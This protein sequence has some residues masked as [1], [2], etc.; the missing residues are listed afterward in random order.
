MF[1][2][3]PINIYD[4]KYIIFMDKKRNIILKNSF[5]T[6]ILYSPKQITTNGLFIIVNL[7]LLTVNNNINNNKSIKCI[8]NLVNSIENNNTVNKLFEIEKN[9]L[10][11]Y[12]MFFDINKSPVYNIY[13]SFY[14][15]GSFKIYEKIN[16]N[17]DTFV[18]K[19]SGIWETN[20]QIGLTYKIESVII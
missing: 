11:N 8:G 6:K 5:F 20:N 7:N 18:Y 14:G 4:P 17:I 1:L 12:N 2:T 16:K 10:Q 9:I 19:I 3:I 13:N 15:N